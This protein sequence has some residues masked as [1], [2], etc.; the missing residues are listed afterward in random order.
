M[1]AAT[2]AIAGQGLGEEVA[3]VTDGRFSGATR[4]LCVG[5]VAPEAVAGGP[6]ALVEEGDEIVLDVDQR[7]IDLLV[8]DAEIEARHARWTPMKPRYETGALAKYA[9]LVG[10]ASGAVCR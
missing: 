5:H 4:G 2:A 8:P 6:I 3:L 10:S 1:L 9:K 7:T